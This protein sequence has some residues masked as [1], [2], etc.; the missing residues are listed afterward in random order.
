MALDE[1]EQVRLLLG[2]MIPAGGSDTDTL[3]T[4]EELDHFLVQGAGN[5]ERAA[6]EGWRAK[7][8]KLSNLVD[9]TEGNE[10]RKYSQLH[11]QAMAMI[12]HYAKASG[13]ET[14][15][16]TR[17]GRIRRDPIPW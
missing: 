5:L 11:T 12:G 14:E 6:Y 7:A 9:T 1:R 8:A 15:G 13:G 2:E 16:R 3:L 4:D 17:V 10:Q